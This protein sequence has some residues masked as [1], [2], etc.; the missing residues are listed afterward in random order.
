[1][2]AGNEERKGNEWWVIRARPDYY[3]EVKAKVRVER[4]SARCIFMK[5]IDDMLREE[6]TFIML[7]CPLYIA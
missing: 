6:I 7:E 4:E 2:N 5:A 1:M 3:T